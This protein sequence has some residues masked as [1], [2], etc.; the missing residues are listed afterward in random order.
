[1]QKYLAGAVEHML[2]ARVTNITESIKYLKKKGLWIYGLDMEGAIIASRVAMALQKPFSYLIPA[3]EI[4]NNADK[5]VEVL[6]EKYE[7]YI[8][9]TDVIVTFETVEKVY[10][11]IKNSSNNYRNLLQIYTIFYR[12]PVS[13]KIPRNKFLLNKTTCVNSEFTAELFKKSKCPYK[14]EQCFGL[15]RKIK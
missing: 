12:R 5:D 2:V 9:I 14:N 1:M 10:K 4:R 7:K 3:K 8:I 13:D 15:N 6:T 11:S